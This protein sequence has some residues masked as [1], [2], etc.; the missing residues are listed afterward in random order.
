MQYGVAYDKV[1]KSN[2][3]HDCNFLA[4]PIGLRRIAIMIADAL[5]SRAFEPLSAN[6]RQ[7]PDRFIR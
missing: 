1:Y 2:K 4:A 3:P 5:R 7:Y 6:D